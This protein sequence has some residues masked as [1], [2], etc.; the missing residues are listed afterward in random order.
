MAQSEAHPEGNSSGCRSVLMARFSA[1]G[2]VAMTVPAIY[3]ACRAYPD[4]EFVM[5]TRPAMT[6][7]FVNAPANLTLVGVDLKGAYSGIGAMRRLA[8]ELKARYQPDVFIDLHNVLR[9]RLLSLWLRLRGVPSVHIFKPRAKRRA[10][11]RRHN[12]VMLPLVSQRAR[13]R[14][15][16]FKA[17]LGFSEQFDGLYDGRGHADPS[18]FAA[19][20]PPKEAGELW[21][22]IAPFAAH[23]GKVYPP[24]MTERVVARLQADADAGV[25]LKVF[26]FGGGP[27]ETEILDSWA[28][29]YDAVRSLAGMKLGFAAELA[30]F[31]HLDAVLTMDSAN[32]HL[33]AIAGAPVLSI[34]GAT[35]TYC[36]FKGWRQ[37]PNDTIELP[38]DCRP[39]SVFGDK[40]CFRGD[41]LCMRAI[42][43]ETVYARLAKLLN[44]N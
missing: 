21:V 13:Y 35:H 31:N 28:S 17:G 12:K 3:S 38:L 5:L 22:G 26:L 16:F 34:W 9:T 30:L 41:H 33:A 18:L 23:P 14:E 19:V 4:V 20:T 10:L 8:A 6:S 36:G 24:E 7:I 1:L 37:S 29:R 42:K 44:I 39:C 43:P 40:P 15:A 32:M 25:P 27:A 11:T 2:D